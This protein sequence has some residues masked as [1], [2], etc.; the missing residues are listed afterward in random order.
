M[1]QVPVARTRGAVDLLKGQNGPLAAFHLPGDEREQ[2][3]QHI[4]LAQLFRLV[5]GIRAQ[6]ADVQALQIASHHLLHIPWD[7]SAL[8]VRPGCLPVQGEHHGI[9]QQVP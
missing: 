6:L 4:P 3:P 2:M 8:L 7:I 9:A 5:A 1:Q